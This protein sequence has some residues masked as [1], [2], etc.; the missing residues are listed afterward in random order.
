M[1]MR[2]ENRTPAHNR[3]LA[4]WRVT[5]LIEHS[6][7]HQLLWCIDSFVLRIPPLRQAPKRS[8]PAKKKTNQSRAANSSKKD[9]CSRGLP[10]PLK[11]RHNTIKFFVMKKFKHSLLILLAFL[12]GTSA[13]L[14]A[15]TIC[16]VVESENSGGTTS[17]S[18][19]SLQCPGASIDF[20]D[21]DIVAPI[22]IYVNVH[23]GPT[24]NG[25]NFDPA[26]AIS[27]ANEL[28]NTANFYLNNMEQ[29]E[30][31]G[32]SGGLS[33]HV[34]KAK[35]QYKI[36]TENLPGD[37]L[38]G[39]W[40]EPNPSSG[41]Y[42]ANV[43]D[44]WLVNPVDGN[45]NPICYS[46]FSNYGGFDVTMRGFFFCHDDGAWGLP[47]YARL[48][49]HEFGH[50]LTLQ[51]VSFCNN[52][53]RFDDIDP[54]QECGPNCPDLVLCDC[55]NPR[56][57][58]CVPGG[59]TSC[60]LP[61][62]NPPI[63]PEWV[64]RCQWNWGN[65]LMQQGI[66][67]NALTPCQWETVFNYVLNSNNPKYSWADNCTEVEP[68]L[69]IASGTNPV[70][71]DL[72]LLN[73][74]VEIEAGATLTITC[75]VRMA[76]DLRFIV[77]RGA[78]LIVDGGIITNLCPDTR[79]GG[80]N[81][82]GNASKEQSDPFGVLT[83]DDAGVVI[84]KN[85]SLIENAGTAMSTTAPGL[86]YPD[87]VARWGGLIYA[88]NSDFIG[89]K[90]V[91]E[92]M[93]YDFPN[94]SKFIN[95]TMDGAGVGYAGATIWDTDNITFE[96]CRFYNM[97]SQ[98]ILTYDAGAIVQDGSSFQKNKIGI[99]GKAT[100]PYVG[101]LMI[102]KMG[103]TPNYFLDNQTNHV[104]VESTAFG[105]G[106]EVVN[107][108]F[109][110]ASTAV[111]VIGPSRYTIRANSISGS[112]ILGIAAIQTGAMGWNQPNFVDYNGIQKP[113]GMI[114]NGPNREMQFICNNFSTSIWDFRL[115]GSTS[116]GTGEIRANQGTKFKAAGNCFTDPSTEIDILTQGPTTFFTYHAYNSETEP[117][118]RPLNPGNYTTIL[119]GIANGCEVPPVIGGEPPTD[120]EYYLLKQQ[121]NGGGSSEQLAG[122]T[123]RKDIVLNGLV[124]DYV[125]SSDIPSALALLDFEGTTTAKVMK[126]GV[127]VG[128]GDY[129]AAT[130]EL[131]AL[132]STDAELT[133]FKQVQHINLARMQQGLGYEL[134]E[135]D[136]TFL[137]SVATGDLGVRSYARALMGLLKSRS[138]EDDDE[139]GEVE[140]R[141]H[142]TGTERSTVGKVSVF[143]NPTAGLFTVKLPEGL[144]A[145]RLQVTSATGQVLLD[146]SIL[147]GQYRIDLDGKPWGKGMYLLVLRDAGGKS[148]HAQTIVVSQ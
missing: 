5:W 26:T 102:G 125:S 122:W 38:G 59:S 96:N 136:S 114:A 53:C 92:F 129:Q 30:K 112:G 147:E 84:I 70:W 127:L 101:K 62:P 143:P 130:T 25:D 18:T 88:E 108:E 55:E 13:M 29:N 74:N 94:K 47:V 148:V 113:I 36:Y 99:E 93:K 61:T 42:N 72:K 60:F 116:S 117:C 144:A 63:P 21:Y 66:K 146:Q 133:T 83:A 27:L 57:I 121:I 141:G 69:F 104:R 109:F 132:P 126:Y 90:R 49:N 75:E 142:Q 16:E 28:V 106:L 54:E 11:S 110:G 17:N 12:F 118:Q 45:G 115:F 37:D 86:A 77:Q 40:I 56:K 76:K 35:W 58:L 124:A 52:Q 87:Q 1:K 140:E 97:T 48:I 105:A 20:G 43:V 67:A 31:P 68:T 107:N 46:G 50:S 123:E 4:Q 111:R 71:D 131:N 135:P 3:R 6:T 9:V 128:S 120:D 98:G 134:S 79:W 73:R 23:F 8:A 138:Y 14:K 95:C 81:V 15:Q 32:P 137:E 10:K 80:I 19:N 65:N 103:S 44:I 89:N 145:A 139:L 51:H 85:N 100:Y 24:P 41:M 64:S 82:H 7:S 34:P 33:P 39:I 2:T 119:T 91:A 78:K 22:T